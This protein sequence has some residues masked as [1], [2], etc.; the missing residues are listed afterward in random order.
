MADLLATLREEVELAGFTPGTPQFERALRAKKI[1]RC[2]AQKGVTECSSCNYFDHCEVAK[3]HLID[4]RYNTPRR[5]P[6]P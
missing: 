4:L 6:A 2:Q 5:K 1:E 3:E